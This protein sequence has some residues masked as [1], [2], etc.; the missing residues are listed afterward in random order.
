MRRIRNIQTKHP[1]CIRVCIDKYTVVAPRALSSGI[2]CIY[3]LTVHSLSPAEVAR[4]VEC[5]YNRCLYWNWLVEQRE[6]YRWWWCW[7]RWIRNKMHLIPK[8]FLKKVDEIWLANFVSEFRD[9]H[10]LTCRV[11]IIWQWEVY[12]RK[13]H[14]I[15]LASLTWVWSLGPATASS[16]SSLSLVGAMRSGGGGATSVSTPIKSALV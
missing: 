7:S 16:L 6:C 10:M 9:I 3:V 8:E 12:D 5:H 2:H 11:A 13:I 1:L 14:M 15:V 4:C